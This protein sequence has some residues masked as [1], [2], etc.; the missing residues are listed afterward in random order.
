[1]FIVMTSGF[2]TVT[3]IGGSGATPE[4][5]SMLYTRYHI[6]AEL[7]ADKDV[8]EVACGPGIGLGYLAKRAR[9]VVGGDCDPKLVNIARERYGNV[10]EVCELN[11]EQLPFEDGTFDVVL[12]LEAIYYLPQPEAFVAEAHRVLRAGGTLFICSANR[13]S[14]G[15]NPSPF[16]HQYY[17]AEEL[18][19][20]LRQSGFTA[21]MFGGFPMPTYGARNRLLGFLKKVAVSLHLIPKTMRGKERIK[22]LLFGKLSSIPLELT[23]DFAEYRAPEALDGQVA[24]RGYKVIYAIGQKTRANASST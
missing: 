12:M 2:T 10:L 15:F 6:A 11:A 14:D 8:L 9:R 21:G 24:A 17:S 7:A 5:L 3:E 22:R 13:E 19:L 23:E 18:N 1:M 20:L 4:Q 16:S